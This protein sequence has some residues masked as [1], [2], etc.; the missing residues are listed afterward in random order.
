MLGYFS[1]YE[2]LGLHLC[3]PEGA[4]PIAALLPGPT[5]VSIF[6][7]KYLIFYWILN[8]IY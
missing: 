8:P 6:A 7:V 2:Q 5:I 1:K 4:T 3:L